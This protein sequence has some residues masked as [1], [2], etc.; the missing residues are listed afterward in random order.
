MANVLCVSNEWNLGFEELREMS[1]AGFRV[2]PAPNGYEAVRQFAS[3]TIDAVIINRRLPDIEV[4]DLLS[5]FRHHNETIPIVMLSAVMPL[6]A[7][8]AGVDAV[9]H[10][11][12][13]AGLLVPT[14]Q[15]LVRSRTQRE[16]AGGES[17]AQ[18]A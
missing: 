18:A 7:V 9:I 10:K 15:V 4:A 13:G 1:N 11:A 3:R 17:V 2:I 16:T 12:S 6:T 5:Y 8:P 14:L